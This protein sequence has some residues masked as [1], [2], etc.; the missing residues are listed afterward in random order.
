MRVSTEDQA[1]ERLQS[2]RTKGTI[3]TF[4]KFKGYEIV[5]Y[6]QDAGISAKTGNYRPEFERLKD[7]IDTAFDYIPDESNDSVIYTKEPIAISV[8][9]KPVK[10]CEEKAK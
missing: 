4:C 3:R 5:D 8:G 7:E 1:R 10:F 2:S 9:V 6:Y